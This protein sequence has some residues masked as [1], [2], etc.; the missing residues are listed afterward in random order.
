MGNTVV[1]E[2]STPK[3]MSVLWFHDDKP[4][5]TNSQQLSLSDVSLSDKG[6]YK[7][8]AA[9]CSAGNFATATIDIGGK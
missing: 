1:L 7:C 6:I 5:A 4:L 2:C 8:C 3:N 9:E